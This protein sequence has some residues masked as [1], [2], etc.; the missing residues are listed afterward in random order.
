M[1]QW[2]LNLSCCKFIGSFLLISLLVQSFLLN[3][4]CKSASVHFLFSLV[5]TMHIYSHF[6]RRSIMLGI[7]DTKW[8]SYPYLGCGLGRG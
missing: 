6:L 7:E 2:P 1:Q 3:S 8:Q 5:N 4:L